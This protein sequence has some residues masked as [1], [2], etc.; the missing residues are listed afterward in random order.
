MCLMEKL[1]EE[2]ENDQYHNEIDFLVPHYPYHA[3]IFNRA[4]E[5][6]INTNSQLVL[7]ITSHFHFNL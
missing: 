6:N 4:K 1:M 7:A 5:D 2:R 3:S